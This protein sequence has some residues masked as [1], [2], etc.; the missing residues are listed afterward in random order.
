M[1]DILPSDFHRKSVNE[2]KNIMSKRVHNSVK[3]MIKRRK[4]N[5]NKFSVELDHCIPIITN[6]TPN[7]VAQPIQSIQIK[8]VKHPSDNQMY[9]N[10]QD[11]E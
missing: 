10:T 5:V 11:T 1:V 6:E 4:E 9:E 3:Y 7:N 8:H 2:F